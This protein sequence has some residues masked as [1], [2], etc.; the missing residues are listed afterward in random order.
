MRGLAACPLFYICTPIYRKFERMITPSLLRQRLLTAISLVLVL[1][2][3]AGFLSAQEAEPNTPSVTVLVEG[4]RNPLGMAL[5]GDGTLFIAEEGTGMDDLSAGVSIRQPDGTI[6]RYI[7]GLPSGRDSGDLSGVALVQISPDG[8]TL[9]V[10]NFGAGHLWTMP[11][12]LPIELPET[13]YTPDDLGITM[14]PLNRVALLNPFAM[15]FDPLGIPVVSD[16]SNNGVAKENTDGTTRFIHRFDPLIDPQN[17]RL[18]IDPV[19]TGI[20]RIGDE[21]YVTLFGGC[22]YPAN[23]GELVAINEQ[24]QQRTVVDNLNM[25]IDVAV[26][27]DGAIWVLEFATFSADGSCFSGS[28]YQQNTGTLSRLRPDGTL[29]TVVRN[30]N[31]PGSIL[32][33]PDGSLYVTEIFDG[34]VL[35]IRFDVTEE[36]AAFSLPELSLSEPQY[37]DIADIDAALR[38]IIEIHALEPQPGQEWLE[39]D[40]ELARLGQDLFFDPILSGDQNISC[41]TCHH[42]AFA[43]ADG[44][45]LPIGT[46]GFGLGSERDF[47]THISVSAEV[48]D[49]EPGE[50]ANPFNGSFVPRNSP[51]II[52][53]ALLPAQFWDGRVETY[54]LG[55]VVHTQEEGV[56]LLLLDDILLVQALFPITSREEMAGATFTDEP[57]AH[58][59][60]LL[61]Q[62]LESNADY[63]QRFEQTFGDASITPVQVVSALAAF[64]RRLIFTHSPWDAYIAGDETALTDQQKRGALLFYGELN[65]E[66]NCA[67][68]HSGDMF[69]DLNY[70]NLL[71]PQIGP[72]KADGIDNREDWGRARVTY[73]WRDRYAFRTPSLRNVELTSPYFHS[74]AYP[75]LESVIWHHAN[76]WESASTYDPSAYLPQDFQSGLRP[77]N[78]ERQSQTVT[79]LLANGLPLTQQDVVD[80]V[81]FL[82]SLT[83][84]NARDLMEFVPEDVPSGLALDP[85]PSI[86]VAT[87][88]E[89]ALPTV[90]ASNDETTESPQQNDWH[91]RNVSEE[92]GLDFQ[93]GAFVTGIFEDPAAMMGAGLCWIDYDNDGWLDLYLVNSYAEDEIDY[94]QQGGGLP[95]N[96]LF[97][98]EGGTFREVST[99][100]GTD[101]SMRGNGCVAADFNRDGWMDLH[102]TADGEN[103]LL[104]NNGDGTFTEG[105]VEA[106]INAAEWN[107]AAAVAD[108]NKDGWPDLFV[109][110]YID[111]DYKVPRPIGAFPQDYY[112]LPDRFYI[113]NGLDENGYVTFREVT[114]EV[115][116][117]REERALGAVFS[118]FDNDGDLD[119]YIANDGQANRLYE[120]RPL[121]DDPL[122]I[123]FRFVDTHETA[124][125]GDTG[126]GMG[127]ASADWDG[128]GYFDLMV[129]NWE[130]ELNAIYRNLTPET[131]YMNFLYSTYRI[132]MR[133]LGNNM[134]GWGTALVDFDHDTDLDL[135][136]VN[137]RVPI[138][139]LETDP[140][141]VQLYVNR[142]AEGKSGEFLPWTNV[143]GLQEVGPLLAR[144]SAVADY[145]NDG[146]LDIAINTISGNAVL[147]ENK[148]T[149]GNWLIVSLEGFNPG[150]VVEVTLDD[151]RILRQEI[152][153][154]SS[155]LASEDPRVH[156]GL[157]DN[158]VR[159]IS[160][161]WPDGFT[162]AISGVF[163]NYIVVYT[164]T[165]G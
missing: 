161:M 64:E 122:G 115:G 13:P 16:A 101:L 35:H 12:M 137:G 61:V 44:R 162:T 53:S 60:R 94:W 15:T 75:T 98:N 80:I 87:T 110:S 105:A 95:H 126:S 90:S 18:T 148:D 45:V 146:D 28:G 163:Q 20:E 123:G 77:Y 145:D 7:S 139:N 65:P 3:F 104:W 68:C 165:G 74:G 2:V 138:T 142:T 38:E 63:D 23:S 114:S 158:V 47:V 10:G 106:G 112:G 36:T 82:Q 157:G 8:E 93:H 150:A 78:F 133:G 41:A 127:V 29:E 96:A 21:Y 151:G 135:L 69:T 154:G 66:V 117:F 57:P 26:G 27:S 34:E 39:G 11:L 33:L 56:N 131:G 124:N 92:V 149:A 113:S 159:Y 51:T 22:P 102:I 143:V 17:E 116:L 109:G 42:P 62:R 59:R 156:F 107:T 97:R 144:G 19:P 70:Y 111:L 160:V 1:M 164:R 99:E 40:T 103:A 130:A 72:G 31:F 155:Y 5:A 147:L 54:A 132:G 153:A 119:L 91:F 4:L 120:N 79:P 55:D 86:S 85:L 25:P 71:V 49:G 83:D 81:A 129:T 9:Y 58:I 52:N 43:M 152:H 67:A 30:L 100:T 125:V 108:I 48:R 32:P 6:G 118:D 89:T 50:T 140:E 46:G 84:P 141:L 121:V 128:D 14:E 136:T 134:T 76:I 73:D 88:S 37:N 24:R